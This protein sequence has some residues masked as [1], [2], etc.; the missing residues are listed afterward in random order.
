MDAKPQAAGSD[1]TAPSIAPQAFGQMG[2]MDAKFATTALLNIKG[3]ITA[4]SY[5]RAARNLKNIHTDILCKP[6]YVG[7]ALPSTSPTTGHHG[8]L[9]ERQGRPEGEVLRDRSG[10]QG[11]G[12]DASLGEE[13]QP[14]HEVG[15]Y[16]E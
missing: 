1:S 8:R 14:E 2:F 4:A 6:W 7:N 16:D 12:P 10:R 13:V 5:N 3:P 11:T 15:K 9:Q